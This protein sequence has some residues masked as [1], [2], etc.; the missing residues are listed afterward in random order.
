M[1][2]RPVLFIA[3]LIAF[4]T[5]PLSVSAETPET[6]T[7]QEII[8]LAGSQRMLSQ[9]MVKSYCQVGLGILT[10]D[11]NV[12]IM[13]DVARFETHVEFLKKYSDDEIYQEK[14]EWVTIAWQR[15]K[16]LITAP[17]SR[18]KVLRINHLAE[19]LLYASDQITIMLQDQGNQRV[20]MM[21]N[22]SGRQRMLSQRLAKLYMLQSWGFNRM[23][24]NDSL[25][26]VT[27]E[28][29]AVL[30]RLRKAPETP[31]QTLAHLEEVNIEWIWFKSALER[32]GGESYGLIVADTS[33][34]LTNKLDKITEEYTAIRNGKSL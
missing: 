31:Q 7:L 24:I 26:K 13:Q 9:R 28:F 29:N 12:A 18:D 15:F 27:A 33:N 10:K 3:L 11:S 4:L 16:P 20:Q 19:D 2:N 1:K 22:V 21:V 25:L 14:L 17:V 6:L 8:N 30:D 23:S 32:H 5:T 34:A